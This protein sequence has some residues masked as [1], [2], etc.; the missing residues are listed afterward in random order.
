MRTTAAQ[1]I[2]LPRTRV[3]LAGW[4]AEGV[5][6]LALL[7]L[8]TALACSLAASGAESGYAAWWGTPRGWLALARTAY[9]AAMAA[10]CATVLAWTLVAAAARL[11]RRW[12]DASAY[13]ACLPLLVPSSLMATAWTVALGREG[14]LAQGLAALVGGEVRLPVDSFGTAAVVMALRYFGLAVLVLT[15][16]WR[17]LEADWPARQVFRIPRGAALVHLVVRP[18]IRPTAAAWLLVALFAM[19]DHIIPGMFLISTYGTQ[20]LIQYS[21]LLDP[22]GAAALAAPMAA[23]GAAAVAVV[24]WEGKRTWADLDRPAPARRPPPGRWG[25]VLGAG[26]AAGVL[27]LAL[28]VPV[29]VLAHKA[30]SWQAMGEALLSARRQAWQ[31]LVLA[32]AAGALCMAGAGLLAARWAGAWRRGAPTAV[33]L[34]LLNLTVP[35]SLLAIG[36]IRLAQT[37]ALAAVRDTAWPLVVGYALRFMPVATL[38]LYALWRREAV[39]PLAAARVHGL[40]PWRTLRHV[41]WP[42]HR[43]TLV[44]AGLLGAL[45]AATEL[46]MS[47][48]LVPPGA[49]TLGVRLYTLIH[50]APESMTSALALDIL[51]LAGPAIILLGWLLSLVRRKTA[52]DG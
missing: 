18:A 16:A 39:E 31:T 41:L 12:A 45:L 15:Y 29:G 11:P 9:L 27:A 52:E 32:S 42:R 43:L 49:G 21:A 3:P 1:S 37:P 26:V 7:P 20:V 13:L 6:L 48:L 47:V 8:A 34:V 23:V 28:A 33:P 10:T 30:G 40:S 25:R 51:L 44:A 2:A 38:A 35:P 46:E 19:N 14:P 5:A 17:R 24:L 4:A 36:M 50:T 22:N